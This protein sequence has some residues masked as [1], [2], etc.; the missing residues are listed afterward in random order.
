MA[1]GSFL[2]PATPLKLLMGCNICASLTVGQN[3]DLNRSLFTNLPIFADTDPSYGKITFHKKS[4]SDTV[5]GM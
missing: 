4:L 2:A 3:T 1:P 5:H